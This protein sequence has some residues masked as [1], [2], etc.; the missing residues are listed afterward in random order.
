MVDHTKDVVGAYLVETNYAGGNAGAEFAMTQSTTAGDFTACN[1]PMGEQTAPFKEYERESIKAVGMAADT[2]QTFIKGY[3]YKDSNNKFYVQNATWLDAVISGTAGATPT[4][5]YWK[6]IQPK[7]QVDAYGCVIKSYTFSSKDNDWPS[8]AIDWLY[9][10]VHGAYQEFGLTGITTSSTTTLTAADYTYSINGTTYTITATLNMTHL[11][12]INLMNAQSGHIAVAEIV[13]ADIRLTRCGF[14]AIVLGPGSSGNDLIGTVTAQHPIEAPRV[15]I[16]AECGLTGLDLT[17]ATTLSTQDYKF[18]INGT[19][20]TISATEN[21]TYI[22]LIRLIN[23]QISAVA[24]CNL[25]ETAGGVDGDLRFSSIGSSTTSSITLAAGS[26]A[27]L[28]TGLSATLD[29]TNTDYITKAFD[30]TQPTIH[31]DLGIVLDGTTY[32][33]VRNLDVK[34]EPEFEDAFVAG[35]YARLKPYIKSRKTT[36]TV[37]FHDS[38]PNLINELGGNNVVL[39]TLAVDLGT[40]TLSAT[41]MRLAES[42]VEKIPEMG[43]YLYTLTFENGGAVVLSTA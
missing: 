33:Q 36:I 16:Y 7:G 26:S 35:K 14:G 24:V 42:D 13:G 6:W 20:Y 17:T 5:Y 22:A 30:T 43:L 10:D 21:I 12:M 18:Q 2:V 19:E 25:V 29:N 1:F 37:G 3:K 32:T 11:A 41:N 4:S 38:S 31:K 39:K 34:I 27:D 40:K 8:E 15:D 28:F 23:A 9:Y